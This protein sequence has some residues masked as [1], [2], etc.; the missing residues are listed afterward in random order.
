MSDSTQYDELA[1]RHSG[2]PVDSVAIDAKDCC[3]TMNGDLI[4]RPVADEPPPGS[5]MLNATGAFVA[6]QDEA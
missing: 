4:R 2:L 3:R 6:S 1:H 5:R